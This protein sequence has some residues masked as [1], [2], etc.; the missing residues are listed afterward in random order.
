MK[1]PT[2]LESWIADF[3]TDL[4]NANRSPHTCRAYASDLYRL[5]A[6]YK[7][8]PA[9]ISVDVLRD[10]LD[11]FSHLKPATRA[12]KQAAL[13]SFFQWAFRHD[14]I[15]TNPMA[16]IESVKR[17][18][19]QVRALERTDVEKILAIIPAKQSRDQLFFRLIFETG[20]RVGEALQLYVEDLDMTLDDEHLYIR[21]KGGQRRT[22][23]LDDPRLVARLRRYLKQT[24]YKYGPLFRAQKNGRGDHYDISRPNIVGRSIVKRQGSIAH[25]TSYATPMRLN[26]L[27]RA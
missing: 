22:V 11:T 7:G 9:A 10:F 24:G 21:G 2:S 13:N 14:L 26:W 8:A 4:K 25:C 17:E 5:A 20:L 1:P 15:G 6:F 19:P 23:L 12:R 27:M 3:L 16:K 18:A